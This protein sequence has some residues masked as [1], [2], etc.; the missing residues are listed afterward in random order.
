[1][2]KLKEVEEFC[3]FIWYEYLVKHNYSLVGE[4]AD[5]T[6]SVIGTGKHEVSRNLQEF[7]SSFEVEEKEWAGRFVI[8][9]EWYQASEAAPGM[10]IVIGEIQTKEDDVDRIV[11]EFDFRFT[12]VVKAVGESYKV[13]H[14]HQSVPDHNQSS[15]EFFPKRIIE[16]SNEMLKKKIEER[17]REL[18]ESHRKVI[19]Y[20]HHDFLTNLMNRYYM[21]EQVEQAMKEFPY[22]A[23]IMLDIDN[24]K[25]IND[26]YGHPVGDE[27][28]KAIAAEMK[29]VF[30]DCFIG[31]VGGDEFLIYIPDKR[32]SRQKIKPL[33]EQFFAAWRQHQKKLG[34]ELEVTISAGAGWYP[35]HGEEYQTLW[36]NVDKALYQMKESG[37]NGILV[38]ETE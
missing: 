36:S 22:G 6:V 20:S 1:M 25:R 2:E 17:T 15:D 32:I 26:S 31:R 34:L 4:Y 9:K 38:L 37:K 3:H 11:Y 14:I 7:V 18:E 23:M 35:K 33:M 30:T 24:Y 16:Q 12:M 21:E 19:H 28:L 10:Y 5:E 29:N 13:L 8:D 27:V